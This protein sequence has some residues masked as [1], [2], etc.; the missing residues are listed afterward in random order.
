MNM[1]KHIDNL[2]YLYIYIQWS[3][4]LMLHTGHVTYEIVLYKYL[5]NVI[6]IC[7]VMFA[8]VMERYTVRKITWSPM[9]DLGKGSLPTPLST[10]VYHGTFG[11]IFLFFSMTLEICEKINDHVF[12]E[13]INIFRSIF[14]EREWCGCIIH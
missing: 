13:Y 12:S 14:F 5:H 6:I 4:I 2:I 10:K 1:E 8:N 9:V 11:Y 3:I 7:Y